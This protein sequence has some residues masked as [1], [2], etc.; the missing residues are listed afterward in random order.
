MELVMSHSLSLTQRQNQMLSWREQ[1]R[2]E[3]TAERAELDERGATL[4]RLRHAARALGKLRAHSQ[5]AATLIEC[6][7]PR[8][9][10]DR[11]RVCVCVL[12]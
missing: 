12:Y 6:L 9:A 11:V 5:L 10:I 4:E 2:K 3:L 1:E 7:L 8:P